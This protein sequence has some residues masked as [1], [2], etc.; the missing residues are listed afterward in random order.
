MTQA[1]ATAEVE[2]AE[3]LR[4]EL[5]DRLRVDG[6]ITDAA[7]AAAFLKV[8]RHVFVPAD[9]SLEDAYAADLAPPTKHDA[10]GRVISSVSAPWLQ[11]VMLRQAGLAPGMRCLEIGSGGYNAALVAEVVGRDGA[12]VSVDIDPE[13]TDRASCLLDAAGYGGRVRVVQAD[14]ERGVPGGG[15]FDVVLVTVGAWDVPP[16]WC[17][18]LAAD[19]VLV[20]PLVMNGIT[21][22]IAFH[23]RDDHLVSSSAEVCGFVPMQGAGC[24]P[25]RV[26]TL[27]D[28]QSRQVRLRFDGEPPQ[29]SLLDGVLATETVEVWSGVTVGHGISFADMYLWFGCFL[30]GFCKVNADEGTDLHAEREN[31]RM[32]PFGVVRGSGLAYLA[33]RPA[34]D[35]GG[36]EFGARAYGASGELAATAL[37]EQ[38][39]AWDQQARHGAAPTFSFW[40]N[41]SDRT[42]V[43][44]GAAILNKTHGLVAITWP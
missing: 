28:A 8:P 27:A 35:G 20:V 40:P 7:V 3:Q 24:H 44:E 33:S 9:T 11:A 36:V 12:V 23:P 16:A 15:C 5:V 30:P 37:V 38:V 31:K 1:V 4:R 39:Q 19:G 22:S 34:M 17:D 13:V 10:H 42:R 41:G 29:V 26:V 2:R 32:W 25:E 18:Q 21:R 43:P 6:A 14:A